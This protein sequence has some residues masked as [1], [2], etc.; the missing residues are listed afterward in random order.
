MLC[1]GL[2]IIG[3]M[4]FGFDCCVVIEFLFFFVILIIFGVMLYE[5]VKDW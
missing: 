2:M 5:I 3:G 4:L 1:L